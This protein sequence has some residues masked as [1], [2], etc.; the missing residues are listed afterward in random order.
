[1][2]LLHNPRPHSS[3]PAFQ[4]EA[5]QSQCEV[6]EE[7]RRRLQELERE[8]AGLELQLRDARR[9]LDKLQGQVS[10]GWGCVGIGLR[11]PLSPVDPCGWGCVRIRVRE[12][13][14]GVDP[15]GWTQARKTSQP[16]CLR[17]SVVCGW[18]VCVIFR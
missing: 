16:V 3:T 6:P 14:S 7:G 8:R 12:P 11:E 10:Q 18:S 5:L 17:V 4:V 15:C 9:D 1:M 13:L 2:T